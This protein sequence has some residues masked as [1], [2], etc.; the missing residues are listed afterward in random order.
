MNR[1]ILFLL[2]SIIIPEGVWAQSDGSEDG[3]AI[4]LNHIQFIGSHNSYKE[5]IEPAL[6]DILSEQ[7]ST[8]FLGLE[9]EHI[10]LT[11]QLDLGLRKLELD[12]FY[13][14]EGGRYATPYGIDLVTQRGEEPLPFDPEGEMNKPGYKVLHIQ[15]IDFRSN[16]LTL[17]AC[18]IELRTWSDAHP[19]HI[20][21]FV[22][23]N[24]KDGRLPVPE[25][26]VPLPYDA[27]AFEDLD[28]EILT[29]LGP[30]RVFRPDDLRRDQPTLHAAIMKYGWPPLEQVRGT[31]VFVLD[32]R[33][34]KQAT[35]IA[36]HPALQR[37]VFFA[38]APEGTPEAAIRIVNNPTKDGAY[39][40]NLVRSGYIVRTRADANTVEAR[41]GNVDRRAAAFHSGAHIVSTDYYTLPNRFGTRYIVRLPE[42]LEALCN[43]VS[44]S[45]ACREE[46][47]SLDDA[48]E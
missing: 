24:A 7:D 33:G 5:S 27:K 15:D 47:L 43:P 25:A 42:S 29:H 46:L 23:F 19:D 10:S 35:Y 8:R 12:V 37:R 41:T 3:H 9:Y 31:F 17:E 39:I 28:R 21:V 48:E 6:F 38:N 44:A 32:E 1:C 18:L 34:E 14:P 26:V 2:L 30:D 4:R 40:R 11:E 36:G 16:C 13:D 45:E 22:T 20:P